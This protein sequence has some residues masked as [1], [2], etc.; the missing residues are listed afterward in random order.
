MERG[1]KMRVLGVVLVVSFGLI[2]STLIAQDATIQRR[3]QEIVASFNKHKVQTK[4]KHGIVREKYKRVH[5]E[6]VAKE[7]AGDYSGLYEVPNLGYRVAIQVG[8]GGKLE[9]SGHEPARR[10]AQPARRFTLQGATIEGALFT[11]TKTY[12]DGSTEPFAG[13]FINRTEF[14]SPTDQGVSAFGLAV[15]SQPVE[16][17][18]VTLD[19]LFYQ[20]QR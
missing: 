6:P 12:E 18:G 7:N 19:K 1:K 2:C 10:G 14:A 20:L 16:F 11:A 5:S 15:V 17:A 3:T 4:E 8:S 9:A 13:V